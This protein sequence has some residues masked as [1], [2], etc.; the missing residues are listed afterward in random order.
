MD[1]SAGGGVRV[2]L[3]GG[4]LPAVGQTLLAD[5]GVLLAG[6]GSARALGSALPR[7]PQA[8]FAIHDTNDQKVPVRT[9]MNLHRALLR[10]A[11]RLGAFRLAHAVRGPGLPIL[12]Y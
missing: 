11:R 12:G 5:P 2:V 1:V 6:S 9:P 3:R 8:L 7:R 4:P 10:T